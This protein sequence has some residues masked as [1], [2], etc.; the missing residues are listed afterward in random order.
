MSRILRGVAVLAIWSVA[1]CA[2]LAISSAL[3]AQ[4]ALA[5]GVTVTGTGSSYAAVAINNWAGQAANIYGIS[6]NYQTQSSVLGLD[7]FADSPPQTNF[8]ASEVGYSAGQSDPVQPPS[9]EQ[10]QYLPDVAGAECMMYNLHSTTQQPI[11]NLQLNAPTLMGIFSGVITKW[12]DPQIQAINPSIAQELPST[13]IIPVIRSDASGDNYIFSEYLAAEEPSQWQAFMNAVS[14]HPAQAGNPSTAVWPGQGTNASA[15]GVTY[16]VSSFL[17]AGGSDNASNTVAES[18]NNG[19]ITYVETAYAILHGEPC[20]AIENA[21]GSFVAPSSEADAIALSHDQLFADLEQNLSGVF[22]A[23]EQAAYPISA[24]SYL[25]TQTVGMNPAIGQVLGQFIEFFA[26]EGQISASQLGYSPLPINLVEDDFAAISRI[27]G[28]AAPPPINAQ[29]CKN[30]YLTGAATYV[31]GPVVEGG[32]STGGAAAAATTPKA[33]TAGVKT[34]S[35]AAASKAL[36]KKKK[37]SSLQAAGGQEMGV[38]L[39][40]QASRLLSSSG[41]PSSSTIFAGLIIVLVALPP[42][43]AFF[44]RRRRPGTGTGEEL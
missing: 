36:L 28:A 22:A 13:P 40:E 8:A 16:N 5:G 25:I 30:P 6:I 15:G 20:A 17:E 44:L 19:A 43:I 18:Q 31:G 7:A 10:Y 12:N 29:T 35:A 26:C 24:Y 14:F 1:S 2:G 3:T 27:P 9:G 33:S 41:M 34:E 39:D 4:P 37:W 42:V 38:A 32:A 23:P 11:Q 21:S